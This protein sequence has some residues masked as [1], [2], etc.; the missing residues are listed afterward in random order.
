MRHATNAALLRQ[1]PG[2]G[3][4]PGVATKRATKQRTVGID[5]ELWDRAAHIANKRRE[6][7]SGV[8]R[9]AVAD[10]VEQYEALLADFVPPKRNEAADD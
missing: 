4:G 9:R 7:V 2:S 3:Y 10:Y 5:D 1:C 6:K 8:M